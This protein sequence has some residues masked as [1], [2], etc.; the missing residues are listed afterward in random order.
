MTVHLL[1]AKTRESSQPRKRVKYE[2]ASLPN[3]GSAQSIPNPFRDL[4]NNNPPPS[5]AASNQ[6]PPPNIIGNDEEHK[7]E[8]LPTNREPGDQTMYTDLTDQVKRSKRNK[9]FNKPF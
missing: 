3:T 9:S 2:L 8:G 4:L 5:A 7:E 1:K 6:V